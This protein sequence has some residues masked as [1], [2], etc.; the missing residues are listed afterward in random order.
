VRKTTEGVSTAEI[1]QLFDHLYQTIESRMYALPREK[2][3]VAAEIKEIQSAVTAGSPRD[4]KTLENFL[5][6]RLRNIASMAPDVLDVV[7]QTLANPVLGLGEV[8]RKIAKK[9][10]EQPNA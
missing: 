8:A 4:K 5:F 6:L 7:M 10:K 2:A 3:A 9:S 1:Q